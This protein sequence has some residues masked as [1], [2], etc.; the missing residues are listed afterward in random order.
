MVREYGDIVPL[1]AFGLPFYIF[2][3]PDQIE[4]ILRHK[5]PLFKK[6]CY[7]QALRP[8]LGD[9]LLT[10]DGESWRRQRM[11]A[12]PLF[13]AQPIQHYAPAIVEHAERMTSGWRAGET[14]DIHAEMMRLT[15]AIV[16]KT[17]FDAEASDV[18]A[19]SEELEAATNFY[20]NPRF[21]WSSSQQESTPTSAPGGHTMH[22]LNA[23]IFEMIRERRASGIGNRTELLSRLL[24]AEDEGGRKMSDTELRDQ[25][26]THFLAGQ[27]TTALTLSYTFY[28]LSQNPD[29]ESALHVE[30]D[31][32]L[33]GRLP[34]A[35]DVDELHYTDW[36]IK[37][38]MRIYPPALAIGREARED[39]E[40]GGQAVPKG[41]QVLMPQFVVHRDPRFWPEPERFNPTR[42]GEERT[43]N[44]PRCAY[45]P[46]G[47]GPRVCIGANL[48]MLEAVLLL[49]TIAQRYQLELG[50]G[51]TLHLVPSMTMRPRDGIKMIV[52][53]LR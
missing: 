19:I 39:C 5:Q 36:V 23:V 29:V 14:R 27:D 44:L 8:M 42:W 41:A 52:R 15:L 24:L 37:E 40:I 12:Q 45:F 38:S 53:P 20:T 35:E 16:I 43:K 28:L 32:V 4:E 17:L 31:R 26:M 9:G 33:G 21:V 48:A 46:F 13:G 30:L 50:Q 3:H 25:L 1:P 49:A 7:L 11:M 18:A 34:T 2:S 51:Q 47:D 10:S 22:R 6:D